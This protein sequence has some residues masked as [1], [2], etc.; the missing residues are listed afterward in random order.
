M[1]SL[2]KKVDLYVLV[3]VLSDLVLKMLSWEFMISAW[4]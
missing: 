1:L 2:I 4:R 3:I